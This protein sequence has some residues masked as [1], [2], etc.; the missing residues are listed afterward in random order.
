VPAD[1]KPV[2]LRNYDGRSWH[3][4]SEEE[5]QRFPGDWEAQV[6]QGPISL[7]SEENLATSDQGVVQ[8]RRLLRRQIETVRDGGDPLGV[9]FDPAQAV[10]KV[11]AG[12]FFKK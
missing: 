11:Q 3:E 2:Q 5:H 9:T 4:L 6:G 1:F 10:V 7:H 8:L 12:N